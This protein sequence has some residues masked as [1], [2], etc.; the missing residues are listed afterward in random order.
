MS[1]SQALTSYITLNALLALG[2][3]LLW[4]FGLNKKILSSYLLK[5]NYGM[6][7]L[8]LAFTFFQPLFPMH[9]VFEPLAK[10]WIAPSAKAFDI[11]PMQS[12]KNSGFLSLSEKSSVNAEH[13]SEVWLLVGFITLLYAGIK[14][15]SDFKSLIKIKKSSF[16]VRKIHSVGIFINENTSVPFSYWQW[17]SHN[18]VIP[19]YLIAEPSNYQMVLAHELQHHRQGDTKWLYVIWFLK[20][21]C[22]INPLIHLW[23]RWTSEIQELA[24]D[25][26]LVDQQKV[27]SQAYARCLVEVAET[28]FHAKQHPV[29]ATGL[30]F[31]NERKILKRRIESMFTHKPKTKKSLI[32]IFLSLLIGIL[33][34]TTYAAKGLVQDR[35]VTMAQAKDMAKI[36]QSSEFPIEVN[37]LVLRYL[38]QYIGTPEGREFIKNSLQRM[39][40]YRTLVGTKLSEYN[41][42]AELMAIPIIESGYQNLDQNNRVKSAGLW[43][44]IPSTARNYGLKVDSDLDERLNE[45]LETDA[46][47]R[48]LSANAMRFKDWQLSVLA[49]N[50]GENAVQQGIDKWNTRSAWELTRK[51]FKGDDYLPRLTAAIL[52]M[53]NPNS[54]Q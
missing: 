36:A 49:Y 13:V 5:L 7:F 17:G 47:M 28:A 25:E 39:E 6:I 51:G 32:F 40:N 24:C 34:S 22:F 3:S 53:K 19:S 9:E 42:P 18:V 2:F 44:F 14:I 27:D 29:C 37:E 46:A 54:I 8:V 1:L 31:L 4:I 48:Y 50:I 20:I 33:A 52:I 30:V 35:R 21:I 12:L 38:N 11:N 16:C 23:S 10:V 45:S 43:M 15:F 41:V 26:A